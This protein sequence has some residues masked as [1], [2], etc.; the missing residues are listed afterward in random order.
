VL[1]GLINTTNYC[2]LQILLWYDTI[3]KQNYFSHN[4]TTYIQQEG[5]AM[6]A[7]SS[8][9]IAEIFLQHTEHTQLTHLSH[10]HKIIDYCRYVDDILIIYDTS[11]TNIHNI[12]QDFN[13]LH[14][15]LHFTAETETD[16]KQNY[17]DI[18]IHRTPSDLKTAIY[19]KPTFTDAII[20]HNS[21]H[22]PTH[23]FAAVKY[24]YNRLDKYHL[25]QDEHQLELETIQTILHN[26]NFP[27]YPYKP[28]K[29]HKIHSHLFT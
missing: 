24:L 25:Q 27:I 13:C 28:K 17:L 9:L 29:T 2:S 8:G 16:N 5:L 14:P 7:P 23:K 10:K 3:T 19:I 4:N 21:N 6:G 18:T 1:D 20:P 11:H 15:N 22:L 12:L 26:N